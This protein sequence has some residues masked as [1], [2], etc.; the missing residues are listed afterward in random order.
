M[1]HVGSQLCKEVSLIMK[2]ELRR[3]I[4]MTGTIRVGAIAFG[5]K[6]KELRFLTK[7]AGVLAVIR[8]WLDEGATSF[9]RAYALVGEILRSELPAEQ[10][11]QNTHIEECIARRD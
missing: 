11:G 5:E 8:L 3:M 9:R 2:F 6:G 1:L 4:S 10:T 7:R